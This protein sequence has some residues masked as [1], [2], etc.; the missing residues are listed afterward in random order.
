MAIP[1]VREA[2]LDYFIQTR[3]DSYGI[4]LDP[5]SAATAPDVIET[6]YA[7]RFIPEG[8]DLTID[9]R[10]PKHILLCWNNATGQSITFSQ[11]TIG[12]RSSDSQWIGMGNPDDPRKQVLIEEYIVDVIDQGDVYSFLWTNNEYFFIMHI[13]T[14]TYWDTMVKIVESVSP[15][16]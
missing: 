5:E 16:T 8:Y 14:D 9:A 3:E 2:I 15:V 13:P 12:D 10:H 1:V 6:V 11:Y 7:V 4:M